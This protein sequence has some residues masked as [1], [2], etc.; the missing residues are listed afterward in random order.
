TLKYPSC[1]WVDVLGLEQHY[2]RAL[3]DAEAKRDGFVVKTENVRS[4]CLRLR[5]GETV[6]DFTVAI[7][8][9][10]VK[11]KPRD[12]GPGGLLLYLEKRAGKWSVVLPERLAV[13]RLRRPQK[14]AGLQGPI[15]DA[16]TAPFLCV[17]GTGE[18]WHEATA[19]YAQAD[20][21]RFRFEWSKYFR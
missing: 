11:G 21:E 9:Q 6:R 13:D 17:R 20:L 18:A 7:D 4:L 3:V 12:G 2:R 19:A 14:M 8:G 16:F 1:S 5:G 10:E 15:D